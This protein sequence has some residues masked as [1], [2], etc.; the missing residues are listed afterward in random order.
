ME[1]DGDFRA[2]VINTGAFLMWV[3]ME[4]NIFGANHIG[5]PFM[6]SLF[7]NKLL[8]RSLVFVWGMALVRV[9]YAIIR[10][11]VYASFKR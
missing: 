3:V 11:V 2:N 10:T 4:V 6:E 5:H 8:W 9:K 7:E 1:R